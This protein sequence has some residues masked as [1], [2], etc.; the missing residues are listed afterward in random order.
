MVGN[1]VKLAFYAT[2]LIL[3]SPACAETVD[4]VF[5]R[6]QVVDGASLLAICGE[7]EHSD[8]DKCMAFTRAVVTGFNY[9][10]Q[11]SK[12][13]NTL[14]CADRLIQASLRGAVT[15]FLTE[16]PGVRSF[17]AERVVLMALEA[18]FPCPKP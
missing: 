12:G 11:F 15:E 5:D 16:N 13:K 3:A 14:F 18:K 6:Q 10:V 2:A 17:D 9:G 8:L 4:E 1:A 7:G